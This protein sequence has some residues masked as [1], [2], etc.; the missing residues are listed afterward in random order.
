MKIKTY[1]KGKK[2][3]IYVQLHTRLRNE[4]IM[5]RLNDEG[6][7]LKREIFEKNKMLSQ[8]NDQLKEVQAKNNHDHTLMQ[9]TM[10][11]ELEEVRSAV[12][13]YQLELGSEKSKFMA[14]VA[15]LELQLSQKESE[16]ERLIHETQ[17]LQEEVKK[18]TETAE[19]TI[20]AI[21][22]QLQEEEAQRI[23]LKD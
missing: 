20:H 8:V 10:T 16:K 13:E 17:L 4:K 14:E 23:E 1:R 11:Q 21:K 2:W 22:N 12:R 6:E 3:L 18:K 7:G 15:S 5:K 9:H 19:Q